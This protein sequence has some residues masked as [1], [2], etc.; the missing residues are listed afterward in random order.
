MAGWVPVLR[1]RN[2]A[3]YVIVRL[4]NHQSW[5]SEEEEERERKKQRPHRFNVIMALTPLTKAKAPTVLAT[6]YQ[7]LRE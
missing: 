4:V 1:H 7:K 5:F 3:V 2:T 6:M